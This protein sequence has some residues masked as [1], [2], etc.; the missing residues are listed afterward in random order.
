MKI[1]QLLP[2]VVTAGAM[3][4]WSAGAL[5]E[6]AKAKF[7][8]ICSECHEVADFEGMSE[9][10]ISENLNAFVAKTK[11]HKKALTMSAA[12][13]TEMSKWLAGGGK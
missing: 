3:A 13:I 9:A 10:E 12:E 1:R 7:E 5:A 2:L 6:A 11:K 4:G 8:S